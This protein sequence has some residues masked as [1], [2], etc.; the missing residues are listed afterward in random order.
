ML[1][2]FN[3]PAGLPDDLDPNRPVVVIDIFRAS[4]SITAALAA[5][6]SAI[7]VAGS[8]AEAAR[9]KQKIGAEAILAGERS[10][11]MI[12]GYD[13]GNSP[14]EM[15]P[16]R[17]SGRPVILNSTNG[18]KLLRHFSDFRHVAV[19]SIVSLSATVK[20]L[21]QFKLDPIIACAGREGTFSAEDTLAAGMIISR[22]RR[23]NHEMDDA[24][25]FARRLVELSDDRWREW[26][27]NSFHGRYLAS[28]GLA[29]DLDYCLTVDKF[30]FVPVQ[31]GNAI[32]SKIDSNLPL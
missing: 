6:A 3:I 11:F 20:Y 15:T 30:D 7:H 19:G 17:I 12:E 24:A 25:A 29:D 8:I 16:G 18:T 9:L 4:T 14:R 32:I 5:G 1:E 2:L 21:A 28:I 31:K 26:A 23:G 13:L 22:L 27:Q 10:G